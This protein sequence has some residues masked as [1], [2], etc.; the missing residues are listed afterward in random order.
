MPQTRRALPLADPT[1]KGVYMYKHKRALDLVCVTLLAA[2]AAAVAGVCAFAVRLTSHGPIL[3]RQQRIGMAEQ[4]FTILKFRTMIHGDNPLHPATDRITPVGRW[5]RR[6]SIDELPQL[7]NV[8]RGE[9]SLVGPR[10]TLAY[11]VER[12]SVEQRRRLSVLPGIT[13][14]AQIRGRN[15]LLWSRRIE[16]DLD[17]IERQSLRL[18]LQILG[19]S[20]WAVFTRK[21]A[22]GHS[23]DDPLSRV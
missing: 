3:F 19:L 14:L 6:T 13:G 8:I 9:M 4:P 10:P 18:D 5:L 21:G 1:L 20:V 17:Y 11:Q 16:Y 22:E 12:Y 7:W 23:P 2:P 15:D